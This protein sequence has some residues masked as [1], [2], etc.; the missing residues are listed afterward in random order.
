MDLKEILPSQ[1]LKELKFIHY[2]C[3][4]GQYLLKRANTFH[5]S[6]NE[7]KRFPFKLYLLQIER[8]QIQN[9]AFTF[10]SY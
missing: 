5:L 8:P 6:R 3:V 2:I 10:L 4:Y 1:N 9:L 7:D